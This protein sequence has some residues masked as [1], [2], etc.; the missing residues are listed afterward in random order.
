M[1]I[2]NYALINVRYNKM[3]S[4]FAYIALCGNFN[5]NEKEAI[6]THRRQ[7]Y[8]GERLPDAFPATDVPSPFAKGLIS[9]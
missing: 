7:I 1:L 3:R 6:T 4:V 8:R 2:N 5:F 9:S